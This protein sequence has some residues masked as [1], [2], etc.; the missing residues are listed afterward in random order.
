LVILEG[1]SHL[2]FQENI[3]LV[4]EKILPW[5]KKVLD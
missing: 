5:I 4:L 3:E 2:I 1:V